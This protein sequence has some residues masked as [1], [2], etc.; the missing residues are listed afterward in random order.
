M[1]TSNHGT[2]FPRSSKG[3]A[4][5]PGATATILAR[6]GCSKVA[7]GIASGQAIGASATIAVHNLDLD[8]DLVCC[9]ALRGVI[10]LAEGKPVPAK[11]QEAGVNVVRAHAASTVVTLMGVNF[12]TRSDDLGRK[13]V[14]QLDSFSYISYL[15]SIL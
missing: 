5:S 15:L 8:L 3:L 10:N 12:A 1:R 13:A 2:G 4:V 7:V 11:K 6:I 9:G 14:A